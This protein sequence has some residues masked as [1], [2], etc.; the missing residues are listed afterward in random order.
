MAAMS[1]R[2]AAVVALAAVACTAPKSKVCRAVCGRESECVASHSTG[3]STF[4]EG[5]C[6]A[7]CAALERDTSTQV[8]VTRHAECVAKAATCP[9]VL[10]CSLK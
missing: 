7:A 1:V 2:L 5:E 8:L 10:D 6:I 4:D 3:E 9:Q